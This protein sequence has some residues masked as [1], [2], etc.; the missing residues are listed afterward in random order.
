MVGMP[1]STNPSGNGYVDYVLW[2]RD[3]KPLAVVEAKKTMVEARAG[4]HQ[5]KLYADCLEAM[6]GQ[7]PVIFYS[8]GFE[9]FLWDDT[10]YP[11]R[12]VYGFFREDEL[13]RMVDR[14]VNRKDLRT[15]EVDRDI[16]GRP[17]QLEAIQR[18]AETFVKEREGQLRGGQRDC[19]M[20]MATGSGKTRTSAAIV[21]MLTK[22]NWAKRVLFLADRTS[23]VKQAKSAFNEHLPELSAIDLTKEKED[24]STRL[25]FSTYPT[26][27]NKI[28]GAKV[29]GERMY[30]AGHFDLIIIDEA[31]RSVYQKYRAIFEYFDALLIGLTATPKTEIDRN[32]TAFS[33]LRMTILRSHT[34]WTWPLIRGI[35]CRLLRT[36]C[37]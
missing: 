31:H 27:I 11:E 26:M 34:N 23:L 20:V 17:Y 9:T 5:A 12:E 18:V 15:F 19:L 28:D 24:P 10:F 29:D 37:R 30:G 36:V 25:V 4:K 22:C 32:T 21:D 3:G 16:S 2:G 35:W 1:T 8:N 7:R 14:R 33:A 13:Q 6:H